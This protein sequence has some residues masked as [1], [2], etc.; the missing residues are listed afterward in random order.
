MRQHA[1]FDEPNRLLAIILESSHDAIIGET[2]GGIVTTWNQAAERIFGYPA[3]EMIGRPIA[4]LTVPGIED[5]RPAIQ[6]QPWRGDRIDRYETILR[7]KN[8]RHLPVSLM[9]ARVRDK[10]GR[11][12]GSL[13]IARDLTEARLAADALRDAHE[14]LREQRRELWHVS[15]LGELVR[16]AATLAH[17]LTQPLTA[18]NNYLLAATLVM[19]ANDPAGRSRLEHA[20]DKAAEQTLRAG[21]IVRR[22]R[23]LEQLGRGDQRPEPDVGDREAAMLRASA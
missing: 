12:V 17:E 16:M 20:I 19:A 6:D 8:G 10:D 11:I 23:S 21:E 18:I 5:G 2:M 13:T 22:L 4:V 9:V 3:D 14:R 15:R 7:H 1:F